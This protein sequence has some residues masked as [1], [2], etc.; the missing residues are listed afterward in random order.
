MGRA[1]VIARRTTK[2]DTIEI[3]SCLDESHQLTNTVTD[4][5]VEEGFNVSDHSRPNPDLVTLRC[6]VSNTPL[7]TEQKTR[8]V[9]QGDIDFNTTAASG[10]Q[11]GA[12]DGRGAN[13]YTKLKKLRDEG[14]LIEVVTTLRTYGVSATEGM[15]IESITIPRTRENFD[16]L[17]FSIN[18]KQIRIVKNRQTTDQ[19][20]KEKNTRKEKKEGQKTTSEP[21]DK[22]SAL[23]K[24]Y[25]NNGVSKKIIGAF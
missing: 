4:H 2:I 21:V 3:D 8:A 16:G 13:A 10:V 11:I 5:P 19:K 22:R 12:V 20:Q 1:V 24:D 15:M 9:R 25:D 6:F 18:L 7:S 14:T 23:A 17:E